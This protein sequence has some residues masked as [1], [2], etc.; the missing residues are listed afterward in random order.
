MT[1]Q[2]QLATVTE[3]VDA[4][5][6]NDIC[7]KDQEEKAI[8][9]NCDHI[10]E[11]LKQLS[12]SDT[13][14]LTVNSRVRIEGMK[15]KLKD[16]L[17]LKEV[18]PS[19]DEYKCEENDADE[20]LPDTKA[21]LEELKVKISET[22]SGSSN[23]E[24]EPPKP[25]VR[26]ISQ[27]KQKR[28]S[29]SESQHENNNKS[30]MEILVDK[31]DTRKVP[32]IGKFDET[33]GEH[34]DSYLNKFELYCKD[35]I[36][37]SRDFWIDELEDLF[38]G[39]TL[40]AFKAVKD[41]GDSYRLIKNK[42][43]SWYDDMKDLRKKKARE[44]FDKIK[45]TK[46][47]TLYLFSTKME[48][49]FKRAFPNKKPESSSSLR[50]KFVKAI[51]KSDSKQ[52]SAQIFSNK[53]DE[54]VTTWSSIQ[55]FARHRDVWIEQARREE[56]DKSD[57][58]KEILINVNEV[59][60]RRMDRVYNNSRTDG[61]TWP[62]KNWQDMKPP[63]RYNQ[64]G[65][66]NWH[67]KNKWQDMK[68][69]QRY[70]QNGNVNWHEKKNWQD[71]RPPTNY[72]RGNQN[73]YPNNNRMNH[74]S[75]PNN[76]EN[77]KWDNQDRRNSKFSLPSKIEARRCYSCGRIGHLAVQCRS[78]LTCFSCGRVGH[79][80]SNCRSNN[81]RR[82]RSQPAAYRNAWNEGVP[83][84][85]NNDIQKNAPNMSNDNQNYRHSQNP[86]ERRLSN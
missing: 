13:K 81:D 40:E 67:E 86:R 9:E 70:N 6:R 83:N 20:I 25:H 22:D 75:R 36:K 7:S 1:D 68:P 84:R 58:P 57:E 46:G 38:T 30:I 18:E 60:P 80:S 19:K 10:D 76:L 12:I 62:T 47:D 26:K 65:N 51:P 32:K 15:N 27:R 64:N 3:E 37:G 28:K 2:Q 23:T 29:D 78:G 79:M 50:E 24:R 43:L 11:F 59:N 35:N 17:K 14:E 74:E 39:E 66:V 52:L 44:Q 72:Y 34:L 77:K 56:I 54:K 49:A 8:I 4:A 82:S 63:Q 5:R 55:K 73:N 41:V 69:P 42:M 16:F 71:V 53:L 21:R 61:V 48:K 33:S 45:F 85:Q 31:I